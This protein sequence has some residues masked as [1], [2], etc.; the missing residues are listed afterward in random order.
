MPI[1]YEGAVTRQRAKVLQHM[2][3]ESMMMAYG[4]DKPK[5]EQSILLEEEKL[6]RSHED[7]PDKPA[8]EEDLWPL[9]PKQDQVHYLPFPSSKL[10]VKW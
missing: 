6:A 1:V 7:G 8:R 9:I 10:L 4:Q 2:F 3:N 5:E